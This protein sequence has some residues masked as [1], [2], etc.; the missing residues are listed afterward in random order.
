MCS[1]KHPNYHSYHS[2]IQYETFAEQTEPGK[3]FKKQKESCSL[4]IPGLRTQREAL[5]CLKEKVKTGPPLV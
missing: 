1:S 3:G 2:N 4:V 5:A